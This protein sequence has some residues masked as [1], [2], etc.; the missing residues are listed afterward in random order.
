MVSDRRDADLAVAARDGD[1][2][3]FDE[4]V[5]HHKEGLFRLVRGYV[6]NSDDAYDIL[7]DSFVA[8]WLA[9][10][11]FDQARDFAAW[12][13]AIALNKCRDFSRRRTVRRRF[14]SLFARQQIEPLQSLASQSSVDQRQQ[15][16]ERLNH[17]EKAVADLP[18]CVVS[19]IETLL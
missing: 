17:L 13:R 11:R 18:S 19:R 15:D 6:G 4:L 12:L 5:S 7:Q 3:A 9:L 10:S 14:L 8:A 2:H 16:E 1:R